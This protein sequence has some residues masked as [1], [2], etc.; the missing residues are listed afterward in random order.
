[1]PEEERVVEADEQE[2]IK[3][4]SRERDRESKRE[5]EEG[6]R[7]NKGLQVVRGRGREGGGE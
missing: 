1:M 7:R 6:E 5:G 4:Q 2:R 3:S